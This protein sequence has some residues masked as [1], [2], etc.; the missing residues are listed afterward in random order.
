[1]TWLSLISVLLFHVGSLWSHFT[2]SVPYTI[3]LRQEQREAGWGQRS[4]GRGSEDAGDRQVLSWLPHSQGCWVLLWRQM[5]REGRDGLPAFWPRRAP[6]A[7][8]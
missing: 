8:P 5:T 1:M 6:A 2:Y 4:G 3:Q 7:T